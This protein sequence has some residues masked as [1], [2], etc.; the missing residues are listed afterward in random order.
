MIRRRCCTRD[1]RHIHVSYQQAFQRKKPSANSQKQPTTHRG[2][3]FAGMSELIKI[4]MDFFSFFL[5]V[6]YIVYFFLVAM[7]TY[8][9]IFNITEADVFARI[10]S[11]SNI[12]ML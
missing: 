5:A 9:V 11:D 2:T 7:S 8:L 6:C 1:K 3:T 4:V 12:D 10:C